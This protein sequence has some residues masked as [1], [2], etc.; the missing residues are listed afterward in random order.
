M[1][2]AKL[3]Q[4]DDLLLTACCVTLGNI[5]AYLMQVT[6]CQLRNSITATANRERTLIRVF[7]SAAC[8][9]AYYSRHFTVWMQKALQRT[10]DGA[11]VVASLQRCGTKHSGKKT[12]GEPSE[13]RPHPN[14]KSGE[15]SQ[16]P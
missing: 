6:V 3:L 16:N 8:I 9:G 15:I 1:C 14:L 12:Y 11:A 13:R 5:E 7:P 4:V 2:A 10:A